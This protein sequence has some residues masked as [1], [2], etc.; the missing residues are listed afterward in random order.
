[1]MHVLMSPPNIIKVSRE[2]KRVTIGDAGPPSHNGANHLTRS[3][4]HQLQ[5]TSCTFTIG[6]PLNRITSN[7]QTTEVVL[8]VPQA[9]L[10]INC[11]RHRRTLL[12]ETCSINIFS[13]PRLAALTSVSQMSWMGV[14]R[15]ASAWPTRGCR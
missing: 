12:L 2:G 1:M 4:L 11:S 5:S 6:R 15:S 8:G 13:A 3:V 7:N 14:W 10:M 9:R